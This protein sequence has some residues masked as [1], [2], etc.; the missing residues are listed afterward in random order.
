MELALFIVCA[1]C[2]GLSL[3]QNYETDQEVVAR[4]ILKEAG[5][6]SVAGQNAVA[7]VIYNR[8]QS[9][10]YQNAKQVCLKKGQFAVWRSMW[11]QNDVPTSSSYSSST[12]G[13]SN[14][15]QLA[16]KIVNYQPPTSVDPTGGCTFF[17]T[18]T[19]ATRLRHPNGQ[20]IGGNWFFKTW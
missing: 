10:K 9:G 19:P 12:P 5:S 17:L 4:T 6:S 20:S 16:G 15:L 18:D 3:Q 14:C 1:L 11:G 7:W 2:I 8:L 13:Y